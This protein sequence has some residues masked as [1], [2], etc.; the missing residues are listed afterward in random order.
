MEAEI[1]INGNVGGEVDWRDHE[2]Y[3]GRATF[4][5]A[6]TPAVQR[7]GAWVELPT[8]WYRVTCWRRLAAN[9]RDS[10][11]KGDAVIVAG[12]LRLDR[13]T[14][15]SG[16]Q[17]EAYTIEAGWV[18]HD[19]RRGAST[20]RRASARPEASDPWESDAEAERITSLERHEAAAQAQERESDADAEV[21]E[22]EAVPA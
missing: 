12:R 4:T 19:L 16:V 8:A 1:V 6:C 22:T 3:V 15:E 10:V 2:E 7:N 14:D 13:W 9:V 20:F 11:R 5:L 17:R 18:A 21:S